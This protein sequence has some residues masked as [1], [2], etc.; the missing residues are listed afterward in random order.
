M[1]CCLFGNSTVLIPL[2]L[3]ESVPEGVDIRCFPSFFHQTNVLYIA[4]IS[5]Y[6][7][8]KYISVPMMQYFMQCSE[9]FPAHVHIIKMR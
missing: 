9:T 1:H 8:P 2:R 6:T 4:K 3:S 5:F 7:F